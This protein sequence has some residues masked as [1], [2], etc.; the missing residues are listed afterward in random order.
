MSKLITPTIG[1]VVWYW[2]SQH[3]TDSGSLHY[4]DRSQPLPALVAYVHS[5][6]L[7]NLGGFDQ[8]GR[9]FHR[10]S[11]QLLQEDDERPHTS[12]GPFAE[13]RPFQKNAA[14]KDDLQ[15][16]ETAALG[17]AVEAIAAGQSQ[18]AGG[19]VDVAEYQGKAPE[20]AGIGEQLYNGAPLPGASPVQQV[21]ADVAAL[22]AAV[23]SLPAGLKE[24]DTGLY[25]PFFSGE[26]EPKPAVN[27]TVVKVWSETCVNVM[28]EAGESQTSVFVFNGAGERPSGNYFEPGTGR[29]PEA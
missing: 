5:D 12:E 1:R 23:A 9:P 3:E 21:A 17:A 14:L 18:Q 28:T 27:A 7:V 24:G 6:R 15:R 20:S 10:T 26:G 8:C 22:D 2:P 4:S 19:F 16:M 11:V 29:T 25:T 13:W